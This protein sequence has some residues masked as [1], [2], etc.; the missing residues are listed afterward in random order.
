M[1]NT[2]AAGILSKITFD[3]LHE[4]IIRDLN[5]GRSSEASFV[6]LINQKNHLREEMA[7]LIHAFE[8]EVALTHN[9]TDG[10]NI[11]CQGLDW[12]RG[13]EVITT[14]WEHESGLLPI[15]TLRQNFGIKVNLID[16]KSGDFVTEL[17]K[18]ITS[19]TRLIVFSHVAWNTGAKLPLDEMV[20]TAHKQG[21]LCLIDGAQS[22]GAIPVDVHTT[23][24]DFYSF[25]AHK[26]LCGPEGIGALYIQKDRIGYLNLTNA[27]WAT[28][29]E[30]DFTGFFMPH[31]GARRF[32]VGTVFKPSI[33]AMI[34]N[35]DWLRNV[36]SWNWIYGRIDALHNYARRRLSELSKI[37][38]I[39]PIE[40]HA[41]ILSFVIDGYD[42]NRVLTKL[43]FEDKIELRV[44]SHPKTL[45]ISTHFYNSEE[46][47]DR[48]VE[49]LDAILRSSPE[50]FTKSSLVTLQMPFSIGEIM[51]E[52]NPDTYLSRVD[53]DIPLQSLIDFVARDFNLG[54]VISFDIIGIGFEDLNIKLVS[55]NGRYLVKV[56]AK[57]KAYFSSVSDYV[58]ALRKFRENGVPVPLVH[59]HNKGFLYEVPGNREAT[60]LCVM[61]YFD[62][63]DFSLL[64]PSKID[65]K[66]L[67]IY[68]SRIHKV[69]IKI[70]T[71][72]DSWGTWHLINEFEK[73][74]GFLSAED[75]EL[76]TPIIKRFQSL[77]FQGFT[78]CV[79]HGDLQPYNILKNK[80]NEYCILD[81]GC[82]DFAPA[83]L[84]LS[85]F[86]MHFCHDP[87]TA[88]LNKDLYYL[89][90]EEYQKMNPLSQQE[91]EAIPILVSAT[92]AIFAIASNFALNVL[93]NHDKQ[94]YKW[95]G[96]SHNGLKE[97]YVNPMPTLQ[98]LRE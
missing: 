64:T 43:F 26:W 9:T 72:Y 5:Q 90:V 23:G 44:T 35:L 51:S 79:I 76:I 73:K 50:L 16:N 78:K 91:L 14:T 66:A 83:V 54:K 27:G 84:D 81:L 40:S 13:D 75:L 94:I 42:M 52:I 49:S 36:A 48:L 7:S 55:T 34:A 82:I 41:G 98:Y 37:N 28:A 8:D 20:Q 85:I 30:Y 15:Y 45:R 33:Y 11:V 89:A 32:D 62:G 57:R 38:I 88:R 87:N 65:I 46:E 93:N 39:T 74:K 21:I 70:Q 24:V 6:D 19:R 58:K 12:R 47:I 31:N 3:T 63:S 86:I 80:S 25:P 29:K 22:V 18:L 68:I 56:F 4:G 60:Y 59:K 69:S 53:L 96:Y 2:G 92:F 71:N 61:D 77:D 97:L 1:L 67:I 95:F 10:L 17:S